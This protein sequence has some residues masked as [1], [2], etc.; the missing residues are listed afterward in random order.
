M[1]KATQTFECEFCGKPYKTL[2]GATNHEEKCPENPVNIAIEKAALEKKHCIPEIEEIRQTATSPE[3]LIQLV[4]EFLLSKGIKITFF[5]YPS[6]FNMSVS[7]SHNSPRGYK[8]N[9]GGRGDKDGIP[10]GYPGWSGR[11]EGKIEVIDP[12]ILGIKK[13]DVDLYDLNYLHNDGTPLDLWFIQTSGGSFGS[14]FSMSGMLWLYDFPKM[15]E[16]FTQGENEFDFLV[17]EYTDAI[18]QYHD[19]YTKERVKFIDQSSTSRQIKDLQREL[20]DLQ[21]SLRQVSSTNKQYLTEKY[22]SE[23]GY[24]IE[25]PP[26]AFLKNADM[27]KGIHGDLSHR[28]FPPEADIP[29]A[30][31][32]INAI[33]NKINYY[34]G[35]NPEDFI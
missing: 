32:K 18:K 28:E 12:T 34:I 31:K 23:H 11:W 8:R 29:G 26:T 21:S 15:Y 6:R 1:A 27:L 13:N 14:K 33:S 4:E 20:D 19:Y 24:K 3:H 16:E 25:L 9:W 30:V 7:N 35:R 5:D 17:D 2:K 10:R 22:N